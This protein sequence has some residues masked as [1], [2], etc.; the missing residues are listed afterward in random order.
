MHDKGIF[1]LPRNISIALASTMSRPGQVA[2]NLA[3]IS[4]Y[5]VRAAEDGA[6]ILLTPELSCCGYGPYPEVIATAEIAG[7]GPIYN[8]LADTATTTN[9]VICAGF[10]EAF[11]AKRHLAHYVVYPGGKFIVQRKHRVT[12]AERP[13]DPGVEL[14]PWD[15]EKLGPPADPA[16]PGQPKELNFNFFTINDVKFALTICA[17]GG[18]DNLHQYLCDNNVDVQLNPAG[19]GGR[20]EDR[21]TTADLATPEG[22]DKYATWL[23]MVCFPG[24]N[25]ITECIKYSLTYVGVN[26]CGYDGINYWHLGH[27]MIVTP[28]GEIPALV[29]GFPN[30]DRMR[31]M[32]THAVVDVN[33]RINGKL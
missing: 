25:R 2:E 1:M 13:L 3:E 18:I 30:I 29:H 10:V 5:A 21:V 12:L 22:R 20:R 14:I 6:D 23:E 11:E 8:E 24:K 17:D 9:V 26:Q 16:N 7:K 28:M 33:E 15:I 27:G 4:A 31:P 32:Y 19:A